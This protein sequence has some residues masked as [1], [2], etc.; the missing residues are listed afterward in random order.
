MAAVLGDYTRIRFPSHLYVCLSL[1][2]ICT[3][4][5]FLY[6]P[7]IPPSVTLRLLAKEMATIFK[8]LAFGFH[9]VCFFR[10][11]LASFDLENNYNRVVLSSVPYV[12]VHL[13]IH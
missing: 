9:F 8:F 3:A 1:P 6:C 13:S 7:L 10:L 5:S 11:C 4:L 12:P 2:T